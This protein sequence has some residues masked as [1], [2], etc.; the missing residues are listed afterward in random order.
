MKKYC[1]KLC[2]ESE[3]LAFQSGSLWY[4]K[5]DD[6]FL[7]PGLDDVPGDD[8]IVSEADYKRLIRR[9]E[10]KYFVEKAVFGEDTVVAFG[11]C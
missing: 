7:K 8:I 10:K 2:N 1:I 4:D 9:L 6:C 3:F 11:Y 5:N